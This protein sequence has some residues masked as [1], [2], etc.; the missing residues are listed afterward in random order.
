MLP[1]KTYAKINIIEPSN[2]P[3]QKDRFTMTKIKQFSR[4]DFL[5]TMAILGI[6][7]RFSPRRIQAQSLKVVI[8]GAG[9]AGLATAYMLDEEGFDVTIL[10]ARNRVGGRAFTDYDLAPYPIELGA[11]FVHGSEVVTWDILEEYGQDSLDANDGDGYIYFAGELWTEKEF[12]D[13]YDFNGD[14]ETLIGTLIQ[15]WV[16][17]DN[18]DVTIKALLD[19]YEE[20]YEDLADSEVRRLLDNKTANEYGANLDELS[21]QGFALASGAGDG[22]GDFVLEEG[23]SALMNAVAEELDI[24]LNTPVTAITWNN[25]GVQIKT[26]NGDII[27]ADK[28]VITL[29]L[30]VLKSNQVTF[31]PPLPPKKLDAIT[32]LGAGHVDKLILKFDRPFWDEE[33]ESVDTTLDTQIWW[34]PGIGRDDELPILTAL[35]GGKHAVRFEGMT[36][37]QVIA[38]GLRDLEEMFDMDNLAEH[39]VEGKFIAWG[40][41]PY[42]LMGYSYVPVDGDGLNEILGESVEDVLFFAGE[43]THPR[44]FATVHGAIESGL[45]AAED[46]VDSIE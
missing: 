29:P 30:G 23:Y 18:D 43:A 34:R 31:S 37:E 19:E 36:D 42:S 13:E 27:D 35:I 33:M 32:R 44:N 3:S 26:A 38:A 28:V 20:D 5:R 2:F 45:R 14:I 11:E 10:E 46:V 8:I 1:A 12:A 7:V 6:G 21:V 40:R 22:N 4:R 41:D 15:E 24:R 17:E 16:D 25:N 39:L 9:A